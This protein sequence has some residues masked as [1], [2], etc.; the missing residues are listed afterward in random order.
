MPMSNSD[1]TPQFVSVTHRGQALIA[2]VAGPAINERETGI[3]ERQVLEAINNA[4]SAVRKLVLNLEQVQF[5]PSYAVGMCINLHNAAKERGAE[6]AVVGLCDDLQ[7]LFELT[8]LTRLFA[9]VPS[10]KDIAA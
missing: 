5:M 9:V 3:I 8:E 7:S 6:S 1:P 2:T 10:M 4:D